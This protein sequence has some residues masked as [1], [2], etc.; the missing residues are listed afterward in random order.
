MPKIIR[1]KN[2]EQK[3]LTSIDLSSFNT[4]KVRSFSHMFAGCEQL[5]NI[6]FNVDG[7]EASDLSYLFFECR[8]LENVSMSTFISEY[9]INMDYMFFGCENLLKID[10]G[11]N[12]YHV[13]SMEYTFHGCTNLPN[14]NLTYFEVMYVISMK[15]LFYGCKAITDLDLR[16]FIT[17]SC[18][19]FDGM[20]DE[21]NDI[22]VTINREYN[23]NLIN[24]APANVHFNF[25]GENNLEMDF[26][27]E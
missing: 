5:A 7:Y 25:P 20:F 4:Y 26:L 23:E 21:C 12:Y 19:M 10:F 2:I 18:V 6:D 3:D 15:H 11:D 8:S 24:A 22:N 17:Y 16:S 27:F 13:Q 14:I 1:D 9:I